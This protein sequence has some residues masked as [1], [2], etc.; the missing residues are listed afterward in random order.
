MIAKQH[1]QLFQEA[2]QLPPIERVEFVEMLLASFELP[3]RTMID[4]LWA[5]EVED[6][7]HAYERGEIKTIAAQEVFAKLNQEQDA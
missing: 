3:S 5:D 2:L 7:I 4:Q 6:R 1:E